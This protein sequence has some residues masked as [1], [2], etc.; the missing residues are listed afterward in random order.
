METASRLVFT[1]LLNSLWQISLIAA[2]AWLAARLLRNGP[3]AHR[4]AVWALALLASFAVPVIGLRPAAPPIARPFIAPDLSGPSS[5]QPAATSIHSAP[6]SAATPRA[7]ISYAPS[8]AAILLVA[9]AAFLFYRTVRL[10]LAL[11]SASLL[12][13]RSSARDLPAPVARAWPTT[14]KPRWRP[15]T[16][17][18]SG[19]TKSRAR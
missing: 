1:F 8:V 13:Q 10:L 12:R 4:H 7:T 9:Y 18:C 2:A 11:R 15:L 3:A 14:P 5:S 6:R 16:P 19:R 17:N